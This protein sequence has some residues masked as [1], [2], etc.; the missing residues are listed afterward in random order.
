MLST[1]FQ[2]LGFFIA[3]GIS[4]SIYQSFAGSVLEFHGFHSWNIIAHWP[5]PFGLPLCWLFDSIVNTTHTNNNNDCANLLQIYGIGWGYICVSCLPL[6]ACINC[7]ALAITTFQKISTS[8]AWL[9]FLTYDIGCYICF[10]KHKYSIHEFMSSVKSFNST[11]G[12]CLLQL[13]IPAPEINF[14][15][16]EAERL[17]VHNKSL[18]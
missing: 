9:A 18:G 15:F 3:R 11:R 12:F 1:L 16:K 17:M 10:S 2:Q 4:C 8:L 14:R 13:T 7:H 5:E 6:T